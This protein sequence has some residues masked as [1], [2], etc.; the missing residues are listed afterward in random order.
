MQNKWTSYPV[1]DVT[2]IYSC[3]GLPIYSPVHR[4]AFDQLTLSLHITSEL[5][6]VPV[7]ATTQSDT[8]V[9]EAQRHRGVGYP[10]GGGSSSGGVLGFGASSVTT[11]SVRPF[12]QPMI[13]RK[14][15]LVGRIPRE[16]FEV[17]MHSASREYDRNYSFFPPERMV[18]S[19][20]SQ[21]SSF[22]FSQTTQYL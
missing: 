11:L 15:R 8:P 13:H 16:R 5:S 6:Q 12:F 9:T 3:R 2:Q 21:S 4:Y 17:R 7:A 19:Q 10:A 1:A 18:P 14:D 20:Q 22:G